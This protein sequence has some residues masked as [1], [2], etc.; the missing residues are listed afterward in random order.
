MRLRARLALVAST[1]IVTSTLVAV[2]AH[3]AGET[4]TAADLP[5]LLRH[6]AET[7][8]PSYDRSRF[9]HWIDADR[10]GCNTRYEVL[11][12]ES[13]TPVT[14]GEGCSLTGGTWVS[15]YDG[16]TASSPAEIEIDHVVALAEAWRSGA[17]GWNDDQRR[18]FANDIDV[19]YAL[20]AASSVSNQSKSDRDPARWLPTNAAY[21]CE[22]VTGWAL[23]KYRWD[24]AADPD[25]VTALQTQLTGDCGAASVSLPDVMIQTPGDEEPPSGGTP[26]FAAGITRLSGMSRYDTAVAAASRYR[27]PVPAVFVAT[28]MNFPDALAAASAAAHL[29]G[30]LLL[31][32]AAT[33]PAAVEAQIRDLRPAA[34]YV[35]GSAGAVSDAVAARLAQYAPV[36]RLGGGDR[37]ATGLAIAAT[38]PS[39]TTAFIAT[40]RAFPDALAASAAAGAKDAPVI[41]VDGTAA[42]LR[43]DILAELVRLGVTDVTIAG[44]AGAVSAGIESQL[45]TLGYTVARQGGSDR[46]AT[47]VAINQANF[48][49][50]SARTAFLSTGADFPDALSG[51]ALAG[52]LGAPLYLTAPTCV[53]QSVRTAIATLSPA[54]TVVMGGASV[55]SDASANNLGCLSSTVPTISGTAKVGNTLQGNAG[56]W[57]A[58]ASLTHQWFVNGSYY[59]G[60]TALALTAG[61]AGKSVTYRV[62][63]TL[64]GYVAL[65]QTSRPVTIAPATPTPPPPP[66][67]PRNPGD[68]VNCGDFDTWAQAQ[69]W[70]TT[71]FPLYGDVA[72]LDADGDGTACE[73][74]PGAPR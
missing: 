8:A 55:V 15:P 63:G 21:T 69:A 29:G 9:D 72:K 3:A 40:G 65:T 1:V 73:S 7:T 32:P 12:E 61:L 37:Y 23:T 13:T 44:S 57:T 66:V 42:S 16:V 54:S 64:S 2:P 52:A 43:A 33:L 71:Y 27:A 50:G 49:G 51:A 48:S 17:S 10:D 22:Y 14:V 5:G 25:E 38:F 31:T 53:P 39:S 11:I 26:E 60:G 41:L 6:A 67:P 74:L 36:T 46:Y 56:A 20:T 47:A 70:F 68:S 30:P 24:L 59:G 34:I 35:V 28:G 4:V 58:G 19:P 18:A 45:R 62:T